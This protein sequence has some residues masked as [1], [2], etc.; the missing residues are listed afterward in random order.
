MVRLSRLADEI[1]WPNILQQTG[2]ILGDI[3]SK[4]K[5]LT[6]YVTIVCVKSFMLLVKVVVDLYDRQ[7]I[8]RLYA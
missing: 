1:I 4:N 5:Q 3:V 7:H 2:S 8:H 6:G